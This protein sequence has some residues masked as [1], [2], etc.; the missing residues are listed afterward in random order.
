M[1]EQLG[2]LKVIVV[3]GKRLV[4]RDFK[5]SDPYVVLKLGNQ[6]KVINSCLNPIWNEELNFTLTK[7][8]GVSNLVSSMIFSMP[9]HSCFLQ[10][11]IILSLIE[12]S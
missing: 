7:P 1:G 6:T 3:Q 2:L 4:I 9:L 8:L 5:T 10:S 12:V 11:W